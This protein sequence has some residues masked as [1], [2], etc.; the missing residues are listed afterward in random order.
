MIKAL[1][2]DFSRTLLFP[3][4]NSY[5]GGLNELNNELRKD[6]SFHF[7]DHFELNTELINFLK[8]KNLPL[9]IFTQETV[10]ESPEIK[11]DVN[12]VFSRIF[13]A[14]RMGVEKSDPNSFKLIAKELGLNPEELFYAD[15]IEKNVK[16]A[17]LAGLKAIQ[18]ENNTELISELQKI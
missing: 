13:V 9:Y 12:K 16:A 15:D 11:D 2:F 5:K 4:D 14:K 3:K 18:Y 8:E 10:Q 6:P 17:R 7:L 1:L